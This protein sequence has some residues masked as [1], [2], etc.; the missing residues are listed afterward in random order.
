MDLP[1]ALT[2]ALMSPMLGTL[3]AAIATA[4]LWPPLFFLALL[5]ILR[6]QAQFFMPAAW[7]SLAALVA[8]FAANLTFAFMPGQVDHHGFIA[9][10]I[11]CCMVCILKMMTEP[12]T[13]TI[14][15]IAGV[16][17]ALALALGLESLPWLIVFSAFLGVWAIV[18]GDR[19]IENTRL[20]GLSLS[21]SGMAFL[22]TY[23]PASAWLDMDMTAFSSTY[24][25]LLLGITLCF[26]VAWMVQKFALKI[27][28][29]ITGMAAGF[30][31]GLFILR[32][33]ELLTGPYGAVNK[34]LMHFM[35][36]MNLE[37]MPMID[38]SSSFYFWLPWPL[39][40][41]G[42]CVWQMIGS[43]KAL[44]WPW[45]LFLVLQ[46][47]GLL[48]A[49]FYQSRY[50]LYA[51]MFGVIPLAFLLQI[52]LSQPQIGVWRKSLF[53][54]ALPLLAIGLFYDNF[55]WAN[56]L[57]FPMQAPMP[58]CDLEEAAL[59]LNQQPY[60]QGRPRL[61]LNSIDEGPELLLRTRHSVLSAPFH[62]NIDGNLDSAGF[63]RTSNASVAKSIA[64]RRG[65]DLVLTCRDIEGGYLVSDDGD[66]RDPAT[67]SLRIS[68]PPPMALLLTTAYIPPWLHSIDLGSASRTLLFDVAPQEGTQIK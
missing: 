55:S 6:K 65:A 25:L 17:L 60:D 28:L 2:I 49:S 53:L 3:K 1:Y 61:I 39:I 51:Q 57:L 11:A 38:E 29:P 40:S 35:L 33:P 67:G 63:F 42:I 32:F 64:M 47:T 16:T 46:L 23:K 8:I 58:P 54:L 10:L 66:N 12:P 26:N 34:S 59:R 43:R 9:L 31:G 14:P 36:P 7:S 62:N 18:N 37:S 52:G 22:A 4:A 68:M 24:I 20:F 44:S 21:L 45:I 41:L 5:S 13:R 30:I 48:L 15:I 50:A 56:V 27:R 19:A